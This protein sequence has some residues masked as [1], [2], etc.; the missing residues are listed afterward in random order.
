VPREELWLGSD[1]DQ[2]A[3]RSVQFVPVLVR[4]SARAFLPKNFIDSIAVLA[5]PHKVSIV[6]LFAIL[7]MQRRFRLFFRYVSSPCWRKRGLPL[8]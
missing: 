6:S 1:I 3:G 2:Q 7:C 4:M 8:L 5:T